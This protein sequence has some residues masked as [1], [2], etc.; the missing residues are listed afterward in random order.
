MKK[1]R[2]ASLYIVL[3]ASICS[4]SVKSVFSPCKSI[5][6][7]HH[8]DAHITYVAGRGSHIEIHRNASYGKE[9][10]YVIE[11]WLNGDI[12]PKHGFSLTL[13]NGYVIER[14]NIL[15]YH[16]VNKERYKNWI[17]TKL[18]NEEIEAL[19][20][21]APTHLQIGNKRMA[22]SSGKRYMK[23]VNCL[24]DLSTPQTAEE[25]RDAYY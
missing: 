2:T 21:S 4:C 14:P 25:W 12:K 7:D 17:R 1:T 3:L 13:E 23:Y 15:V 5:V 10:N 22:I 24:V 6:I 18:T 20:I 11:A 9:D 16:N 8:R 19:L